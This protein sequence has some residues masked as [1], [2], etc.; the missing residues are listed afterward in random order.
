MHTY[1]VLIVRNISTA[2]LQC[3]RQRQRLLENMRKSYRSSEWQSL[4]FVDGYSQMARVEV[5]NECAR[6]DNKCDSPEYQ[7]QIHLCV[8]RNG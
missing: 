5:L 1:L 6:I 3:T 7:M 4:F 2:G 8:H